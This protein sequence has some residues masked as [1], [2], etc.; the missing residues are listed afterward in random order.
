[1]STPAECAQKFPDD[2][3][4]ANGETLLRRI[5]E[6]HFLFD[7][8]LNRWRPTSAAFQDDEDGDPMSTYHK[9]LIESEGG[10]VDR[11]MRG[12]GSYGLVALGVGMVRAKDQSVH[13]DPLPEERSHTQVCGPKPRKTCRDFAKDAVWIVPPSKSAPID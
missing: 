7:K 11:V 3:S 1:M 9:E 13:P 8:N 6:R 4:I 12:H 2:P 10:T 5:P